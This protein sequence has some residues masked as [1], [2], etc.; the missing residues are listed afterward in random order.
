MN[1]SIVTSSSSLPQLVEGSFFHS[2]ELFRMME[3]TPGMWP[4]MAVVCDENGRVVSNM[5]ACV[6]RRKSIFPLYIL[7]QGRIYGEGNYRSEITEPEKTPLF[8]LML[9]AAMKFMRRKHCFYIEVSDTSRKMFGYRNF[10]RLNFFPIPWMQIHNS[11][12]SKAPEERLSDKTIHR[13]QRSYKDG[14][15]TREA[16][17]TN[18]IHKLYR[19]FRAYFRFRKQRFI[20]DEK[21]FLLLGESS[22]GHIYVTVYKDRII[23]GSVVVDSQTDSMLWF[24]VSRKK[25]HPILHPHLL[26]VWHAIKETYQRGQDHIHFLNVGLPFRHN[27]YRDFILRFGGKP[28]S[29]YR[30]FHFSFAPLNKLLSWIYRV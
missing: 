4:C 28:V 14:I 13:I 26:T 27:R 9:D 6:R 23:G 15:I 7:S 22:N 8:A 29:S 12:H 11:L 16:A 1:V 19:L 18:E 21:M 2:E 5:L 17:G 20:P 30:W 10:R 24:D 25:S 3:L